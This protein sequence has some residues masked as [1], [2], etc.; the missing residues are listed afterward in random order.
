MTEDYI[1]PAL[2]N[3]YM[4]KGAYTDPSFIKFQ[5]ETDKEIEGLYYDLLGYSPDVN[6]NYV[7]D[8]NKL[9]QINSKGANALLTYLRVRINKIFS[10]SNHDEEDIRKRCHIF[11]D[12][13]T[14]F[15]G[16]HYKD[17]EVMSFPAA[18]NIID[19]F[20]DMYFAT[21]VK[22]LDGWEG[23]SIRKGFTTQETKLTSIDKTPKPSVF[24][25]RLPP[26]R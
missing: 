17:F 20:D 7:K 22:S 3:Y 14:Y 15:I 18:H 10:L 21:L 2:Q 11:C 23:D 1:D 12:G 4:N 8:P 6:G 26:W 13:I 16:K 24:A 5:L 25:P 19:L 9:N